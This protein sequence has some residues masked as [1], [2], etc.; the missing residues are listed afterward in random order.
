M[1]GCEHEAGETAGY[2][3]ASVDTVYVAVEVGGGEG[4]EQE[5][6]QRENAAG[7]CIAQ[8]TQG[9]HYLSKV[10]ITALCH[11]RIRGCKGGARRGEAA[12]SAVALKSS[13]V[14]PLEISGDSRLPR[15]IKLHFSTRANFANLFTPASIEGWEEEEEDENDIAR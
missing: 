13:H 12:V 15:K 3:C 5:V 6:E 4:R 9:T 10:D 2:R 1:H 8:C 7:V 11:A 14:D